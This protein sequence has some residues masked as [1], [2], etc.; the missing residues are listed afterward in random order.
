VIAV[1]NARFPQPFDTVRRLMWNRVRETGKSRTM[2][3]HDYNYAV[4]DIKAEANKFTE[5]Q[6]GPLHAGLR[7]PDFPVEDLA[8][9]ATVRMNELWERG[10][11][12][13]EFGSFT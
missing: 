11:A 5:F 6:D 8:T 4:F 10:F 3:E 1:G 7:A 12:V 9:G 13:I 2:T